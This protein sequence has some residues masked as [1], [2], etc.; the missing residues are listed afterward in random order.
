M[1]TLRRVS[2]VF[3][4]LMF[5]TLFLMANYPFETGFPV[6]FF[7][8]LDP[9]AG[10]TAV[11][12]SRAYIPRVLLGLA[13]LA[14]TLVFGRLFCGWICPLG[15]TVDG[16]DALLKAKPG[17]KDVRRTRLR[18]WKYALLTALLVAALFSVQIAGFLDPIPL[19]TR[20]VVTVL[21]PLAVLALDGILSFLMSF[22]FLEG[23]VFK[24]NEALRGN[25]LPVTPASFRGAV[26]I[27]M[28]FFAI[29]LLAHVQK[30]FWCRNLCPLGGLLGVFSK[31]RLY[32]RRV[33]DACSS[34]KRCFLGCRT[35]AIHPDFKGTDHA[36]CINCMDCQAVCPERAVRFTFTRK[37]S[38][39]AVD[40][41]R[42]KLLGA[43]AAGLLTLG[44]AKVSFTDYVKKGHV[45][46]PPG[47]LEESRF[48]DR[49][50]RCGECIRICSTSGMGL[51]HAG[52]ESGWEGFGT[53]RLHPPEGY[54]EYNCNLCGKVCPTGA[55]PSLSMDEK[56]GM[57]MGTAH[58]DKTHC[59]PW[60]YG[61]NCMVCEEH[62]PVPE[63]AIRFR[64]ERVATIDGRQA[65]VLLPY[66]VEET[67]VGCGIC[68]VRCPVEGTKGIFLT[69]AGETRKP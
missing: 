14:L 43:G 7:L 26:L 34:C 24:A 29:L 41:S 59:I 45:V 57:K 69:N 49:C 20:T 8:R 12:A 22:A 37:P 61:E 47:S 64:K 9:L 2:Q 48:L 19:F 58:F 5:F 11:L 40:L 33:T 62:C 46:R 27:G 21:Y 44:V 65:D 31:L 66:V 25:L 6:D 1:R 32:R 54:C 10:L 42:R 50:I 67:C 38:S 60:Y 4:I 56:H 36:E 52:L 51:Q 53:P 68:Q 16:S 30:R 35:G 39:A 15:T 17:N 23:V 3:F 63:K 28:M 55:I 13:T 18:W